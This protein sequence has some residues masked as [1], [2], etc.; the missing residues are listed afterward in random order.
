MENKSQIQVVGAGLPRTGTCSLQGALQELGYTPCHHMM[1]DVIDDPFPYRKGRRW[2]D[3]WRTRDLAT[4]QAAI[5]AIFED[6][7]FNATVDF[8]PSVFVDDLVEI[9]PDAKVWNS[10]FCCFKKMS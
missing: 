10:L 5:R 2:L 1:S 6:G 3:V 8:P 7:G 4:R 9:Y